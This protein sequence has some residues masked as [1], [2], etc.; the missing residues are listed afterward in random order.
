MKKRYL[1]FPKLC[2]CYVFLL[3]VGIHCTLAQ[4][5]PQGINYQAVA[6]DGD[7]EIMVEQHLRV[8]TAIV[9][10]SISGPV[11]YEELHDLVT[12]P[13]GHFNLIIGQGNKLSGSFSDIGWG[14]EAHFLTV[15]M[16]FG[17]G[18]FVELG[19]TQLQSVPY[20]LHAATA[21]KVDQMTLADL[22]DVELENAGIGEVL[23]WNGTEWTASEDESGGV[24]GGGDNQELS[25][26][27]NTG[28]LSIENGN[29]VDLSQLATGTGGGDNWGDQVINTSSELNGAGTEDD[30]LS[31]ATQEANIGQVLKWNGSNWVP[32]SD[33]SGGT[34][35]GSD[36]QQ[37][38]FDPDTDMLSIENGNVVDLSHLAGG[39]G[40]DWG[41]QVIRT[42]DQLIGEGTEEE[43]LTLASQEAEVGEVLK[44]NGTGWVPSSDESGGGGPGSDDQQLTFDPD[45][46]MLS[47]ENGNIV[48][49]SH[50]AGGGEGD[51]WGDQVI[52]TSTVLEGEGT[53]GDPLELA[54][55]GAADGQVLKWDQAQSSWLPANDN[56][57][58]GGGAV[59]TGPR[60]SGDGSAANPVDIA[61]QGA[62]NGE[63]LKWDGSQ[64]SPAS[65]IEG[66][67]SSV[68]SLNGPR[69]FYDGERAFVGKDEELDPSEYF[70]VFAPTGPGAFG[71]MSMETDDA[72]GQ[73]Y[74]GYTTG[75]EIRART[76][77]N[78][79]TDSW[80]LAVGPNPNLTVIQSGNVGIGTENPGRRF[81]IH[82]PSLSSI[83][84]TTDDTP[85][86][87]QAFEIFHSEN[88]T[89]FFNR[90][91]TW[92]S[93]AT[94]GQTR[95]IIRN[96]GNVGI[97][98]TLPDTRLHVRGPDNN[99]TIAPL[100]IGSSSGAI[101][102]MLIDGNEIDSD[103]A[104]GL[105]LNN[106]SDLNVILANGG[107]NVGVGTNTPNSRLHVRGADNNGTN[108][109]LRISSTGGAPNRMLL[110]G[111]EIDSDGASGLFL[112]N[113]SNLNVVL[114]NGGGNVGIGTQAPGSRLHVTGP[115]NNGSNA[116]LRVS[117]TGAVPNTMLIDG[118]EID[119]DGTT[120]LFLNNNNSRN[121]V[122][123]N[124]G[125]N[126]GIGGQPSGSR[127][128]QI[129]ADNGV[130]IDLGSN[131]GITMGRVNFPSGPVAFLRS[132]D[133][134]EGLVLG[135][136]FAPL[137]QVRSHLF[138]APNQNAY[139]TL[140]DRQIKQ[141]I[142]PL[143][144]SIELMRKIN[145]YKYDLKEEFFQKSKMWG[146]LSNQKGQ[147]GVIAQEL[148]E[149]LPELVQ[150]EQESG[151]K[152]VSYQAL[153]PYLL[154]AVKEQ[155][156][157]I[158]QL[159]SRIEKLE[160]K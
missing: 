53:E 149:I 88:G 78:G 105:F 132:T 20:S 134:D 96:T 112:N 100:K 154:D 94:N 81:H 51:D 141:N 24:G 16:D 61:Q 6:R 41:D 152:V 32:S 158:D 136:S 153:I 34:G 142:R 46:D 36:D 127:D 145:V 33:E 65:D 91:D 110:D 87:N 130:E 48:D 114:A 54:P 148:E 76:Y 93:F 31:L 155:Q 73:P 159:V 123:A 74:Y 98:T 144:R 27:L 125:G 60:L 79:Q 57:A 90:D 22:K 120:G 106:N 143:Q 35:A 126:V 67:G 59:N 117:S 62:S 47:I 12:S 66:T 9:K 19:T 42:S 58:D 109:P 150:V 111:N 77:Y 116:P 157:M 15:S 84:F 7:G 140:S 11:I 4:T 103:G 107:G 29:T 56:V 2:C 75:G 131:T 49:L 86:F 52:A 63:V 30:P 26:D 1:L 14:V 50:L 133:I 8:K 139:A 5:A 70:G 64:W 147:V 40:D 160:S 85:N 43:P 71:G 129:F 137:L 45:T 69:A 99:G 146:Q 113:N 17:G 68:W 28:I 82:D 18:G 102:N 156:E 13:Y 101:N 37:L 118:N 95:M 72:T 128:L 38:N 23:K 122:L 83:R 104:S 25:F 119:S 138:I 44:W 92:L 135:M 80:Q 10:E 39:G 124:G 108:A 3:I 151:L 97:G 55:Q 21:G 89:A 121:V 115:D